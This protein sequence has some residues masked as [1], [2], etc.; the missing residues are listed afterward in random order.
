MN[1]NLEEI[2]SSHLWVL[3]TQ[4]ANENMANMIPMAYLNENLMDCN[5]DWAWGKKEPLVR[6]YMFGYTTKGEKVPKASI[7]I[8]F[9]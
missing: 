4:N 9:M 5:E 1:S 2:T 7:Y 6:P 8:L 3:N